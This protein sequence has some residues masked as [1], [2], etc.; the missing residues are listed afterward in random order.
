MTTDLLEKFCVIKVRLKVEICE[1][2]YKR[3]L[4]E[5]GKRREGFFIC[6]CMGGNDIDII[7]IVE[8]VEK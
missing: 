8:Y 7:F 5:L 4:K 2:E 6:F 3:C 1:K